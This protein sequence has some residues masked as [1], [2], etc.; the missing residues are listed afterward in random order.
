[1]DVRMQSVVTSIV[2]V[3]DRNLCV[4]EEEEA[5]AY[6]TAVMYTYECVLEIVSTL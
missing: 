4:F 6:K 3:I 1:M 5:L 2:L